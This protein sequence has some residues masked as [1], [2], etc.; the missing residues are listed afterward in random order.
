MKIVQA[1]T[2]RVYENEQKPMI[3]LLSSGIKL[4]DFMMEAMGLATGDKVSYAK[5]EEDGDRL[6]L[7]K[8]EEGSILGKNKAFTNSGLAAEFKRKADSISLKIKGGNAIIFTMDEEGT[9][10]DGVTY[11]GMD[12][13]EVV[14]GDD[15]EAQTQEE[16]VAADSFE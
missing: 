6:Y 14:K 15:S 3:R 5:D 4:T 8:T 13:D 10:S 11:F 7:F 9:E 2:K 12:F 1:S 16:E